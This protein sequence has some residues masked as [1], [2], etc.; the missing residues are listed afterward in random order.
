M[1]LDEYKKIYLR[2]NE[3]AG[4]IEHIKTYPPAYIAH[5]GIKPLLELTDR[6]RKVIDSWYHGEIDPNDIDACDKILTSMEHNNFIED[7]KIYE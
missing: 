4:Y 5:K 7:R 6:L 1:T 3:E 2:L